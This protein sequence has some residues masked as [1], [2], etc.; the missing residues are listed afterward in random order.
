MGSD[1]RTMLDFAAAPQVEMM[2]SDG[3]MAFRHWY[4]R[5][6]PPKMPLSFL[7]AG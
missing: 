5:F 6:R 4:Q 3:G 7:S 2:Q 1:R